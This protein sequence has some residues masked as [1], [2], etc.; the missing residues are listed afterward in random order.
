M[1]SIDIHKARVRDA[2][3]PRRDPYF[4]A[5]L[6]PGLYLGF[7]RLDEGG[8]WIARQREDRRQHFQSLG[9][10]HLKSYEDA[11]TEARTW[12]KRVLAGTESQ[13]VR[14]V[15]DACKAYVADRRREKGEA[16]AHDAHMRLSRSVYT[17]ALGRLRL[18]KLRAADLRQWRSDLVMADASKNRMMGSLVAALNFAVQER[19]VD[20]GKAMEWQA[21]KRFHVTSRRDVYLTR[22]QRRALIGALPAELQPLMTCLA[23]L[24]LRPSAAAHLTV[25]HL[26]ART[27]LLKIGKDKAHAGRVIPLSA[28]ALVLLSAQAKNKTLA[29]HLFAHADGT[30]FVRQEWGAAIREARGPLGLPAKTCAYSFRHSGITD[31]LTAGVDS[32]TVARIAGTSLVQIERHYGHLLQ[33]HGAQ[34]LAT[35]SLG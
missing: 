23:L 31:L 4:G 19:Y 2:L 17:H 12:G 30:A 14:T 15:I 24:P 7:R 8:T 34:A 3:P 1:A 35:L 22:D 25:G 6:A 13:E 5:P 33:R 28:D 29:E 18:D 11:A 16:A 10:V 20:P 27:G 9:P 26:D 32:L 21:I